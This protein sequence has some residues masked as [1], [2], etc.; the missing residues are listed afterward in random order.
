[1]LNTQVGFQS[2]PWL[3][4]FWVVL[5]VVIFFYSPKIKNIETFY[6]QRIYLLLI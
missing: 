3:S 6:I 2:W 4:A 1:M 5:D